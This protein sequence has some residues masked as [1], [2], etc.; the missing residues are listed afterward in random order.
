MADQTEVDQ[1]SQSLRDLAA[2]IPD[3]QT[4]SFVDEALTCFDHGLFR[5]AVVMSW[6]AAIDLIRRKVFSYKLDEFNRARAKKSSKLRKVSAV[7]DFEYYKESDFLELC[8]SAGIIGKNQKAM[9]L[10]ALALRNSCGHPNDLS[11]GRIR[12]A[13]HLEMLLQNVFDPRSDGSPR[14]Q[15]VDY[16]DAFHGGDYVS[17]LKEIIA[18]DERLI[19]GIARE[20]EGTPEQWA[21]IFEFSP[22]TWRLLV[23]DGRIRGY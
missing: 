8:G 5:S 19:E 1:V 22:Y 18:F 9:L 13:A 3:D 12:V 2:S 17:F 20:H 14:I 16:V 6:M 11:V 4:K 21:P 10:D 15:G 7:I 23:E